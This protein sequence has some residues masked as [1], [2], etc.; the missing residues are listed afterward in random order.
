VKRSIAKLE[1]IKDLES[2]TLYLSQFDQSP[3]DDDDIVDLTESGITKDDPLVLNAKIGPPIPDGKYFIKSRAGHFCGAEGNPIKTVYYYPT[4]V[5]EAKRYISVQ[6]DITHDT[7]DGNIFIRSL[8]A[9]SSWVGV[10]NTGSMMPVPWRLIP[11][12]SK[13]YY[14]TTDMNRI[15]KIPRVSSEDPNWD[16]RSPGAPLI[17]ATLKEGDLLQM[18]EFIPI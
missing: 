3:L 12:D 14:L 11:A 6:W 7:D 18:W 8:Y 15:S 16:K 1:K 17:M 2:A 4:T 9:P 10:N 13:S 5:E